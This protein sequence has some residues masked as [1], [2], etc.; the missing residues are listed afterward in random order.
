MS[1][2]L[3][4]EWH[5]ER[6][7]NFVARTRVKAFPTT[8]HLKGQNKA[9]PYVFACT[10]STNCTKYISEDNKLTSDPGSVF[11]VKEQNLQNIRC[12]AR[13]FKT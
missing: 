7:Q 13:L 10:S 6:H 9:N 8:G 4:G 12:T 2:T 3:L 5:F 11:V 1:P